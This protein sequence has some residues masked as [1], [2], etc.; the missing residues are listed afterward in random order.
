LI[1]FGAIAPHGSPAFVAGSPTFRALRQLRRRLAQAEPDVVVVV[2]PHN[3]HVEG[4]FA[5]V[6]AAAIAGALD[7]PPA[8]LNAAVD[9]DLATRILAS[10]RRARVPAVGVS[11]GSNDPALAEM[12]MDWGTLIPLWFLGGR[13]RR[14]P[15]LVVVSPARDRPLAEHVRAGRALALACRGRRAAVVAS[16][17][18]GHRHDPRGPFGYDSA[19]AEYDARVVALVLDN[20]LGDALELGAV[21]GPAYADS[22]WQLLVLHGALG[23]SFRAEL[24]SY[25]VP[26]YFGM[27]CAAFERA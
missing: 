11:F 25:E 24:L 3:V 22:L 18:H 10:L 27:L 9:R 20:R 19:A 2:T 26:T 12:P 21:A 23:G 7:D 15:K 16:A 14:P 5:V 17:D 8:A 1:V 6:T 13:A 4:S